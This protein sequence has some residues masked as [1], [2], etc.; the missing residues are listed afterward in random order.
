MCLLHHALGDGESP[1]LMTILFLIPDLHVPG[2]HPYLRHWWCGSY[3]YNSHWSSLSE[4]LRPPNLC[5]PI[6]PRAYPDVTVD[7]SNIGQ[8]A[9]AIDTNRL[10]R[11]CSTLILHLNSS[12][13]SAKVDIG[14]L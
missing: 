2:W 8:S 12:V 3:M 13:R 10:T 11:S 6:G 4:D 5:R 1:S 14:L 7:S 9:R